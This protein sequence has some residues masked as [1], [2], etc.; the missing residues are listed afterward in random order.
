VSSQS[1]NQRPSELIE[2]VNN[3]IPLVS[4]IVFALVVLFGIVGA[5]MKRGD[6]Q[7]IYILV[8]TSVI[9][10]CVRI[11]TEAMDAVKLLQ[12]LAKAKKDDPSTKGT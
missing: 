11:V 12:M 8:V 2:K 6:L 3:Y 1:S 5:L 10:V 7:P 4:R 9:W